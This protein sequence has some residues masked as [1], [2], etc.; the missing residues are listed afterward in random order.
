MSLF[1]ET[2]AEQDHTAS[3]TWKMR[4]ILMPF[5]SVLPQRIEGQGNGKEKHKLY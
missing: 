3:S 5:V 4:L 2:A 1:V